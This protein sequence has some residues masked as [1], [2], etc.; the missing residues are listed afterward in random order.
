MADYDLIVWDERLVTGIDKIDG[1][2]QILINLFNE[3][4]TQLT[5]DNSAEFLEH[6]TRDLLSYALY[7]FET[8]EQLMQQ[9]GYVDDAATHIQQHRSFSAKVVAVR[10]D[11]KAGVLISRED[12]LSFL[13][14]WL[15]DHI[16][17][18][19]KR[20]ADFLLASTEYSAKQG[21]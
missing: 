5:A 3:A 10:N 19:D 8:E 9:Y 12:L 17:N 15:I 14:R 18:T 21:R 11:I 2:H 4:N 16:F 1:Q 7:H 20:L 13:N 6:I